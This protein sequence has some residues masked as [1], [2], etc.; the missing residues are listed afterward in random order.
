MHDKLT[1]F[2]VDQN[3]GWTLAVGVLVSHWGICAQVTQ[4]RPRV[5]GESHAHTGPELP[6]E[7]IPRDGVDRSTE[8]SL[9]SSYPR[10]VNT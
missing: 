2:D 7:V 6:A 4:F 1:A 8:S 3:A 10:F 5:L 9:L